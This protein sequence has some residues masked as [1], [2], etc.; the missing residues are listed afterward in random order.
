MINA[1]RPSVKST[2]LEIRPILIRL[3]IDRGSIVGRQGRLGNNGVGGD[4]V[5]TGQ[6]QKRL[7]NTISVIFAPSKILLYLPTDHQV[8]STIKVTSASVDG[9]F[10]YHGQ[11]HSVTNGTLPHGLIV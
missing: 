6:G 3:W 5:E 2:E 7:E 9:S 10:R 1:N 11:T 8:V 4:G